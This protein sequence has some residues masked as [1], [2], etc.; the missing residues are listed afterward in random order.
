MQQVSDK[1]ALQ[2]FASTADVGQYSVLYQL[3]Y[4]P[5]SLATGIVV[6]FLSPIVF[7]RYSDAKNPNGV[8]TATSL[9]W[10]ITYLALLVTLIAFVIALFSHT[11]IFNLLV[12]SQYREISY[13]F[14]WIVLSGGLF[15]SG[16]MLALKILSEMRPSAMV[17][18]K[19]VTSLVGVALN[20]LGASALNSLSKDSGDFEV[21]TSIP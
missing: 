12:S 1:W 17:V 7:A 19:I 2:L 6:S 3:G 10:K 9:S 13:L 5:I 11:I 18:I 20:I 14:P 8:S 21:F 4:T 15:A 16:Q